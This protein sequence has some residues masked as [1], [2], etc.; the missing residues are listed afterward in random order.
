MTIGRVGVDIGLNEASGWQEQGDGTVQLNGWLRASSIS[1]AE[2]LRDQILGMVD[3]TDEP[4]V[5]V[6]VGHDDTR[7]GWYRVLDGDVE[8]VIGPTE[9]EGTRRW[10]ATLQRSAWWDQPRYELHRYGGVVTNAHSIATS[11][12][13]S[14]IA[15]P[16]SATALDP[17]TDTGTLVR[18][19]RISDTGSVAFVTGS[20]V[21]AA[22]YDTIV[23]ADVPIADAYDGAATIEVNLGSSTY[24][25]VVGRRVRKEYASAWQLQN[26]LLRVT[27]DS[28]DKGLSLSNYDNGALAW[29]PIGTT[30]QLTSDASYTKVA[31]N[32]V[33]WSVLRNDP[34][35]VTIRLVFDYNSSTQRIL[36]DVSLR[37]GDRNCINVVKSRA[38]KRW[39]VTNS[40]AE[41]GSA[42]T[43]GI[44]RNGDD[45]N[46]NRWIVCSPKA[47]TADLTDGELCLD[48]TTQVFPFGIGVEFG[49]SASTGQSTA[50]NVA[51]QYYAQPIE[52]ATITGV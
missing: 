32:P 3:S 37:R 7:N 49:G 38:S 2:H 33:A 15:M 30:F 12:Y 40:D 10:S 5:P 11:T 43:G 18:V 26:G 4:W 22:L 20:G 23:S 47:F 44:R 36:W 48:S 35:M 52:T 45:A 34:T 9:R 8:S 39:G 6:T 25:P 14:F 21:G 24:R 42:I 27:W 17:G 19:S 13:S 41:L 51:Y 1:Y 29:E 28:T 46:S 50:Q 16:G 31:E